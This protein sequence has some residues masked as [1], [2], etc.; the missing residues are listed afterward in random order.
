MEKHC[1]SVI[2]RSI[3]DYF[4]EAQKICA[5]PEDIQTVIS[6][7]HHKLIVIYRN[8][9]YFVAVVTNEVSPLYVIEILHRAMDIFTEYFSECTESSLKENFVIV[10]ELLDEMLDNG[11]PLATE[12]NVLKELIKPPN[13]YRK[14]HNMVTGNTK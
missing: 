13:L 11:F 14:V 2:H 4:F 6:T 8:K 5:K 1:R 12:V 3:C 9:L 10:Y 7:P